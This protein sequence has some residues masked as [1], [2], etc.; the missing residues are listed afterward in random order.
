MLRSFPGSG[1]TGSDGPDE[2]KEEGGLSTEIHAVRY[3]SQE[4]INRTQRE[5]NDFWQN[6]KEILVQQGIWQSVE[7]DTDRTHSIS[8]AYV[9]DEAQ[10]DLSH[11]VGLSVYN[12]ETRIHSTLTGTLQN[13]NYDATM[14]DFLDCADEMRSGM[15]LPATAIKT[16][17]RKRAERAERAERKIVGKFFAN[18]KAG[19]FSFWRGKTPNNVTLT[20]IIEH[21][22]GKNGNRCCFFGY[23]GNTTYSTLSKLQE[24]KGLDL[25]SSENKRKTSEKLIDEIIK[26]GSI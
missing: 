5:C 20:Q 21:A 26:K 24:F 18:Y 25:R 13:Q 6:V 10:D 4:V 16:V 9:L 12:N 11:I 1:R 17:A 7:K 23:N 8:V 19:F 3:S 2:K 15:T 14:V 22:R